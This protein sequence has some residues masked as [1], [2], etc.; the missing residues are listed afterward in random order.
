MADKLASREFDMW[1]FTSPSVS[2]RLHLSFYTL[3]TNFITAECAILAPFECTK[4][5]I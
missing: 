1:A 4:V 3:S 2:D 5:E